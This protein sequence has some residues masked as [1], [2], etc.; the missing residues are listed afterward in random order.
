MD[1]GSW[2]VVVALA[3]GIGSIWVS[4]WSTR[5]AGKSA[6][7]ERAR[8]RRVDAYLAILQNAERTSL[9]WWNWVHNMY[10]WGE[11]E[12]GLTIALSDIEA[13]DHD[14]ANAE[15]LLS[16]YGNSSLR[17]AHQDWLATVEALRA[18]RGRLNAETIQH[19]RTG[20]PDADLA[21]ALWRDQQAALEKLEE[22]VRRAVSN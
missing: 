15:A 8:G 3:I 19:E 14:L 10:Y 18:E 5:Y 16:A 17:R 22:I 13:R 20:D 11:I 1:A 2:G 7:E 9:G 6:R 21:L 4:I 12:S